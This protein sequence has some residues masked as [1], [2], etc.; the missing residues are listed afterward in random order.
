MYHVHESELSESCPLEDPSNVG[1]PV[2]VSVTTMPWKRRFLQKHTE[3][4]RMLQSVSVAE[5]PDLSTSVFVWAGGIG[6]LD[7]WDYR[8]VMIKCDQEQSLKSLA[9]LFRENTL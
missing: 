1:E 6:I 5:I 8:E 2:T 3:D 9:E 4:E 7:S